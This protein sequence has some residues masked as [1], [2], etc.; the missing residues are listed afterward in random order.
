MEKAFAIDFI[1]QVLEQTLAEE[2]IA[3]PN[4]YFGGVDQ[5]NLFSFYEQLQKE[6]EIDRYVEIYRDLTEQ[7]NRTGLIMNG[8]LI[9][10]ENP[11]ITNINECDIIPMTFTC[12]FRVRLEDRDSAILTINHLI[13][14]LKGRKQD[15]AMLSNGSLIK[16]GT[17]ANNVLGS[18]EIANGDFIGTL[19]NGILVDTGI[20]AII[21]TLATKGFVHNATYPQWLYYGSTALNGDVRL[22]VA[23]R[24]QNGTWEQLRPDDKV[25][26]IYI[27]ND[28]TTFDKYKL[29]LSFDSIRCDEPRNLNANEYCVLSFGGSATLTNESIALGNDLTKVAIAKE[30][31]LAQ[32]PITINGNKYWL[33]PLETPNSVSIDGM[34]N[35]LKSNQFLNNNHTDSI[36]PTLRYTFVLDKSILLLKEFW[37][38]SR[39]GT[40]GNISTIASDK[41]GITPN[42][43]Y[44]IT[45]IYS[46]WGEI[47]INEFYVKIVDN[48]DV[49]IAESDI[50]TLTIP[51]QVQGENN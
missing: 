41:L 7:Q 30:K 37:K 27:P 44:K 10:P 48:I 17:L 34:V 32:S 6:D 46:C 23:V 26:G 38:Y 29:S 24:E 3:N 14:K 22:R 5:V 9:A 4:K 40:Q 18:P 16:V 25:N 51:F 36:A 39:Y 33:E 13:E 50:I 21:T 28:V 1:R 47:E 45:E 43:I 49:D 19:A 2:H 15:I 31:I 35:Q 42:L 8:T 20:N 12:S 11:T